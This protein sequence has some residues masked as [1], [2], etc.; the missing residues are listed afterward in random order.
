M[1]N[2]KWG[3]IHC[4]NPIDRLEAQILEFTGGVLEAVDLLG[5]E[6]VGGVLRPI[7]G[8]VDRVELEAETFDAFLPVASF[9]DGDAF[10]GD[11]GPERCVL[12]PADGKVKVRWFVIPPPP[13]GVPAEQLNSA[14]RA[15]SFIMVGALVLAGGFFLQRLSA[16][17]GPRRPHVL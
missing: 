1:R 10:H 8:A 2:G 12:S 6:Q 16:Q 15:L 4:C 9:G 5:R 7:S 14:A 17:I 3:Y 11:V 13:A